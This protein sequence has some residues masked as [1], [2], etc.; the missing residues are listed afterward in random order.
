MLEPATSTFAALMH[1]AAE[2]AEAAVA[3]VTLLSR[4]ARRENPPGA[5]PPRNG[6]AGGVAT[7]LCLFGEVWLDVRQ[8]VRSRMILEALQAELRCL[9]CSDRSGK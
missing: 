7:V 9:R 3:Y 1:R 5:P 8:N 4:S 2:P 6:R